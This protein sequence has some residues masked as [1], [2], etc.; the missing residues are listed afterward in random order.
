MS[1]YAI[2]DAGAKAEAEAEAPA[3][4][5]PAGLEPPQTAPLEPSAAPAVSPPPLGASVQSVEALPVEGGAACLRTLLETAVTCRSVEEVAELVRLLARSG[6]APDAA[7]QALRAAAV[8]RPVEDVISLAVLLSAEHEPQLRDSSE[9]RPEPMPR[10]RRR[11]ADRHRSPAKEPQAAKEETPC[12]G[13]RWPVA[14]ALAVS[15]LL[16]LPRHP[17]RILDGGELSA[18]VL[19]GVSAL[20]LALATL[21]LVRSSSGV[22]TATAAAGVALGSAQAL[23][24]VLDLD[25]WTNAVAAYLPWPA[26]AS[27]LAAGLAAVLSGM[28]LLYRSERPQTAPGLLASDPAQAP[29]DSRDALS[30]PTVGPDP[31]VRTPV[32]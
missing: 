16:Y 20:C 13:L 4:D 8:F 21:A 30:D 31:E 11:S 2:P 19:L 22:W 12:R 5:K 32:P 3:G 26:G 7:N 9:H 25:P 29:P 17:A 1:D 10:T 27:M 6:Q 23:A 15:A 24:M 14:A 18:W 28:A